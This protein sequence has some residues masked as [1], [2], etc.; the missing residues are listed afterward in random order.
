MREEVKLGGSLL[1]AV[2]TG[3]KSCENSVVWECGWRNW[4]LWWCFDMG[5]LCTLSC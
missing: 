3:L 2:V 1:F 4:C 5:G